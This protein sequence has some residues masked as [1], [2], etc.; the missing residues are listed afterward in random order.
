M[1]DKIIPVPEKFDGRFKELIALDKKIYDL[2][3]Q[4]TV[5]S[6][7][8]WSEI[9]LEL[10][11]RGRKLKYDPEA[12]TIKVFDDSAQE[13]ANFLDRVRQGKA[14]AYSSS[15]VALQPTPI[16][17]PLPRIGSLKI[18]FLQRLIDSFRK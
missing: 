11:L 3:S 18:N 17:K 10:D 6:T 8:L 9:E 13:D 16:G 7:A 15:P 1:A 4:H 12:N 5:K 2:R 14:S